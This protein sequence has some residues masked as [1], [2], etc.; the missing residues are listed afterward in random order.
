M[1]HPG[2]D[3]AGRLGDIDRGDP[4]HDLLALV[5][6]DLLACWHRPS[7]SITG[8]R[9]AARGLGWDTET[10]TGVLVATVRDPAERAPAPD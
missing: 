9:R 10:L 2:T 7:S 1:G 6:L 8:R 4:A 3:H 5:D